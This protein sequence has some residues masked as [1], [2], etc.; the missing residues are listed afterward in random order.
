MADGIFAGL[1]VIDCAS[2]IAGP[3]AA[4]ILSDFGAKVIK[5]EPPQT[6]DPWRA[7]PAVPG[8][9]TD[10]WW[11]LTARNKQ[12]LAIDLKHPEG[13]GVLHRLL[14]STDVFITNFPLPVRERL[15]IAAA[16]LLAINPLLV[17]GSITAYSEACAGVGRT[18]FGGTAFCARPRP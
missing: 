3:A 7:S 18:S 5:I 11:Q 15:K 12:S 13:L 4:T 14:G 8:K 9:I 6:G 16:D 2:W 1:Q 17:Y 10:Y